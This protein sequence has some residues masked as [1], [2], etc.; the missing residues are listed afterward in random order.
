MANKRLCLSFFA[1]LANKRFFFAVLVTTLITSKAI[2]IVAN[3]NALPVRPLVLWGSSFFGQDLLL[4]SVFRPLL[5][6]PLF[7]S[8]RPRGFLTWLAAL[9]IGFVI[10]YSTVL[11]IVAT[12]FFA[13]NGNE[14]HWRNLGFVKDSSARAV[15]VSG[16]LT[17]AFVIAAVIAVS[18]VLQ[19]LF[20]Y[21]FSLP[22]DVVVTCW[23]TIKNR[24]RGRPSPSREDV[25]Y[26]SLPTRGDGSDG[27]DSA[28]DDFESMEEEKPFF[29]AISPTSSP[30]KRLA[31][32]YL[33]RAVVSFV[34]VLQIASLA[35][36]PPEGSLVYLSWT[37]P[38][39]PFVD[40]DNSSPHLKVLM[41]KYKTSI[42]NSWDFVTALSEPPKF[43]WLPKDKKLSGFEDW[44]DGKEHYNPD[45][46]PLHGNRTLDLLPGLKEKLKHVEIRN[47]LLI[48]LESTR[49]DVFPLKKDEII[50][51]RIAETYED[52]EISAEA[53][54]RMATLTPV[55]NHLTG[56]FE[57]G[58]DHPENATTSKPRG[59]INFQN[60]FTAATYTKKSET[61]SW[62][63]VHPLVADFNREFEHHLYQPCL[64]Q[65]FEAISGIESGGEQAKDYASYKWNSYFME[66]TTINYDNS[67]P[68][69]EA[70]GFPKE[71]TITKEYLKRPDAKFGRVDLPDINYFGMEE[72]PLLDYIRDAFSS[73]KE[74]NER[75]FLSHIT[76][77]SHHPYNL[78]DDEPF[79]K[80]SPDNKLKD[81][82]KYVNAIGYDD[83][84]LGTILNALEE[85]GVANETLIV[86]HG[87]H[88]LSIPENNKLPSYYN[89]NVGCDRVPLAVSHPMLPSI[90]VQDQV[91][92]MQVLPTILDLLIETNS[93]SK[94]A[95]VAA[96]DLL[97]L[98]EGESLIR[99]M[100]TSSTTDAGERAY[101]NWQFIV[102]NPGRAMVG[103][104]DRLNPNWRLVV[105]VLANTVWKYSDL[106]IDPTEA[107]VV[108]SFDFSAFLSQIEKKHGREAAQWAEEG[109][110]VTRWWVEENSK[111][112]R[113]GPYSL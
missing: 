56:D 4:L 1:S 6:S 86:I 42:G 75:V 16:L 61:G 11:A 25:D 59:G 107:D 58:F 112:W 97:G 93:L 84:W 22:R 10:A 29:L 81:L 104:R 27:F 65:I 54:E 72:T 73:A 18:R 88:G 51:N 91:S 37:A 89:P 46:D 106:A 14:L 95:T 32:R 47:V 45:L 108:E 85:E 77:T 105:P 3:S 48:L 68:L 79:T 52:R 31:V 13:F 96:K 87:D 82:G 33:P 62:C 30:W 24:I 7:N 70:I 103:V 41:P 23:R 78:P 57:D 110:F 50:W 74:K 21:L 64:P 90:Q 113:F 36:R 53:V 39:L 111:R 2:H 40:F 8:N 20:F 12:T 83:R 94:E 35:L 55:A 26:E 15:L 28:S 19:D 66:S 38:L 71:N 102:M 101:D 76:S 80:L 67:G 99:K 9:V 44:Y 43:S 5:G 49:K 63:G 17:A 98:Y 109:A 100:P 69:F 92:T 60:A 34:M